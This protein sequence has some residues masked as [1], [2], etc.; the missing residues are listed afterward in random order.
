M[1][2]RVRGGFGT[3]R[4]ITGRLRPSENRQQKSR[5]RIGYATRRESHDPDGVT[6]LRP[7]GLAAVGSELNCV[8][9][10]RE[11]DADKLHISTA[12]TLNFDLNAPRVRVLPNPPEG[13]S[14][15][16]AGPRIFVFFF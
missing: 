7:S 6:P 13:E 12:G 15:A 16:I 5:A 4:E 2:F 14:A 8:P 11:D 9:V 1:T 3:P 10:A